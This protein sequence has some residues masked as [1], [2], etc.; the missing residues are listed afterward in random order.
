MAITR[1]LKPYSAK[2]MTTT[3]KVYKKQMTPDAFQK[4]A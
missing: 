3:L 2:R 1:L 4:Q